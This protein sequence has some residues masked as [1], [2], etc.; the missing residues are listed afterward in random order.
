MERLQY[1]ALS[2]FFLFLFVHFRTG[3]TTQSS[4][5]VDMYLKDL[6]AR[7]TE[8]TETISLLTFCTQIKVIYVPS[9]GI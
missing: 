2:F 9:E 3:S 5:G 6:S 4:S 7:Q 8:E 1:F